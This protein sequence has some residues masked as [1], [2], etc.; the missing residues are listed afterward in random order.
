MFTLTISAF[1]TPFLMSGGKIQTLSGIIY[2]DMEA[3]EFSFVSVTAFVL[4]A[5]SLVILALSNMVA[6]RSYARAE[7]SA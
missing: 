1:V 6:R 4:L 2:R 5:V 7:V 3:L